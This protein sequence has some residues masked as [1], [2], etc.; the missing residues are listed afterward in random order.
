VQLGGVIALRKE[1]FFADQLSAE[2][3]QWCSMAVRKE[4]KMPNADEA[5]GKHMEKEAA[6]ELIGR[7][8]HFPFLIAVCVILPAEAHLIAIE[9]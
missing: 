4:A 5:A 3:N 8:G 7:K 2:C 1:L 9:T 6:Q